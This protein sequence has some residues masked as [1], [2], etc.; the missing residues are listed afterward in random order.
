MKLGYVIYMEIGDEYGNP[1]EVYIVN[2]SSFGF[3]RTDIVE[4][5]LTFETAQEAYARATK[6]G[7]LDWK[8]GLR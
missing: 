2:P 6:C 7:L 3:A 1:F 4:E 8:V 5:A